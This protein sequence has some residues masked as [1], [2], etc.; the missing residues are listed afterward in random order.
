MAHRFFVERPIAAGRITLSGAEAHH[1]QHVL[2]ASPGTE[3]VLFDGQ[4]A[5]FVARVEGI[6]RSTVDL[7]VLARSEVSREA[8]L[9]LILCVALPKQDR[10][11]WLIEKAVELGVT[12]V[13]PIVTR[14]S[15]AH[16][17]PQAI[18]RL[19]R[20]VIEASKQ[21]GRNHLMQI[22]AATDWSECVRQGAQPLAG[23]HAMRLFAHPGANHAL[24]QVAAA[25]KSLE[26]SVGAVYVAVGPEGGFTS[27]EVLLATHAGWTTVHLGPRTLRVE[28]AALA[29]CALILLNAPCQAS[30]PHSPRKGRSS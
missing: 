5:E 23:K 11:R 30:E 9:P 17:G 3:V 16:G 18:E 13:V 29:M 7:T 1:L 6:G 12:R 14:Q 4:G 22:S 8:S 24:A 20:S 26:E 2:R 21:C 27:E 25:M 10:A 19:R 28:T 15:G